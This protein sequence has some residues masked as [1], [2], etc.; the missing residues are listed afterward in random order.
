MKSKV[1]RALATLVFAY[2][3]VTAMS[4]SH[5]IYFEPEMP[6]ALSALKK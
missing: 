3:T 6:K 2:A 5:F 4:A 1:L